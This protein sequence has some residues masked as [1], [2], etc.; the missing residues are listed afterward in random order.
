MKLKR[1][2]FVL[3]LSLAAVL[4][5]GQGVLAEESESDR[6][7]SMM[8]GNGMMNMMENGNMSQMMEAMNSPEGQKMM[9]TC[10][11]FM[12]SQED[13]KGSK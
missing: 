1:V 8:N 6:T 9:R 11:N 3:S 5:V 7:G 12:E 13:G 2:P 10:G 4:V